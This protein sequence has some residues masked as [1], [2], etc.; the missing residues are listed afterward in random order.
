VRVK[1]VLLCDLLNRRSGRSLRNEYGPGEGEIWLDDVQCFGTETDLADCGHGGWN[2]H[3]CGHHE[4][5]SISC[6]IGIFLLF[7]VAV[8]ALM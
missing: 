5:V 4:D 3:N 6:G 8:T 2:Q 7:R 1:Y